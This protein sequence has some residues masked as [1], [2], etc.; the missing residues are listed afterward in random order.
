VHHSGI[1][2]LIFN[3]KTSKAILVKATHCFVKVL[4]KLIGYKIL[5]WRNT[6]F[7]LPP[8]AHCLPLDLHQQIES[9]H[10]IIFVS[11]MHQSLAARQQGNEPPVEFFLST[12]Q[13]WEK[14]S[15]SNFATFIEP[16]EVFH[17]F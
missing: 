17:L 9:A 14:A 11:G 12:L 2:I 5:V 3:Q 6:N 8:I 1:I 7:K 15:L 16:S 13:I 10:N 4:L